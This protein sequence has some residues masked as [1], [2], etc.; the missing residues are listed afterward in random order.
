MFAWT[1]VLAFSVCLHLLSVHLSPIGCTGFQC[2][3]QHAQFTFYLFSFFWLPN[4]HIHCSVAFGLVQLDCCLPCWCFAS[5]GGIAANSVII[6]GCLEC[7]LPFQSPL[8]G[9]VCALHAGP[10]FYWISLFVAA[11]VVF[12]L[13]G[14]ILL[15][16]SAVV[17]LNMHLAHS[18]CN[19]LTQSVFD[20]LNLY[21][22]HS[23]CIQLAQI[24]IAGTVCIV[25]LQLAGGLLRIHYV[26]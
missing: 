10:A 1:V 9:S 13:L 11:Q 22:T 16:H 25:I 21:L 18:I 19:W 7:I 6:F 4:W 5:V 8:L 20:S 26:A 2:T 15:F 17:S 24:T 14:L 23:I 3:R 12:S